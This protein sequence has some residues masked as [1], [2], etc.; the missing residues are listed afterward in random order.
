MPPL[1]VC[2]A[3][4]SFFLDHLF[5]ERRKLAW[6]YCHLFSLKPH[7][8]EKK[9]LI[10]FPALAKSIL[11]HKFPTSKCAGKAIYVSLRNLAN[12]KLEGAIP[13]NLSSCTNLNDLTE[14]SMD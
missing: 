3:F 7:K 8:H 11:A 10:V 13:E 5:E 4:V 1:G 6:I 14:R 2:R 9:S 12:N